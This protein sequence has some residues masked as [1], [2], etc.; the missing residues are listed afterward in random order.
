MEFQV[1]DRVMLKVSP[2]KGIIRFGKRGKL[3]PRFLGPFTV[4]KHVGLQAYQLELLPEMNG[5]HNTFHVCYVR[6][7]LA[8]EESIIPLSEIRV[9]EGNCCV[10]EP[11]AILER[12]SKKL[13]HKEVPMVKVQWKYHRGANVTWKAEEDMKRRKEVLGVDSAPRGSPRE[14]IRA[15]IRVGLCPCAT[16]VFHAA[17]RARPFAPATARNHYESE[18]SPKPHLSLFISLNALN[19]YLG[20]VSIC[21]LHSSVS[22]TIF[23]KAS[24]INLDQA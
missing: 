2:W 12:K 6:K 11:E 17:L 10:D 13:R 9:D 16:P 22:T 5:I 18:N 1:D 14:S 4:L 7:C 8:E 21:R 24:I 15:T 23:L 20:Q 3:R 19:I